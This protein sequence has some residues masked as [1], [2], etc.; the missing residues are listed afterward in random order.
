MVEVSL[1]SERVFRVKD[2]ARSEGTLTLPEVL[3]RL[4]R[5][6]DLDFLHLRPHQRPAWHAF[7]VQLAWLALEEVAAPVTMPLEPSAWASHLRALTPGQPDDAPWCLLNSD[8]QRPAFMQP[9]CAADRVAEFDKSEHAV[10]DIDVLVT[11][12]H[13]DE[14]AAKVPLGS[15][16]ADALVYALVALQGWSSFMGAGNYNTMR[17]NGGFGSRPHFRLASRRGSGAEFARDFEALLSAEE[18]W[19]ARADVLGLGSTE[20]DEHR[21]LWLPP[22]DRG[23]LP[24]RSVH[25]LCLEVTRRVRLVRDAG[26]LVLRRASSDAMRVAAKE[27][28][29]VV[30]DPWTPVMI[31]KAPRALTAHRGTLGYRSLQALLF[32]RSRTELPLLAEP[33]DAERGAARSATLLAQILL[34]GD[35]RTDGVSRREVRLPPKVLL[36]DAQLGERLSRRARVFVERAGVASGKVLRAALIQFLDGSEEVAWKNNDFS[37]AAQPWVER[38]EQ[39]IDEAFFGALFASVEAAPDDDSAATVHWDRWLAREAQAQLAV[40]TES[41]PTRDGCRWFAKARAE[42]LMALSLHKHLGIGAR[43][44]RGDQEL[45]ADTTETLD[46]A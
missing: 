8:W 4:A 11:S 23:S 43:P 12:R 19:R 10:Q 21:L 39:A 32:D 42:R 34:S 6:D 27:A 2:E 20:A 30:G 31:D 17:M 26:R 7:L 44:R 1:L 46:D 3:A 5:Q 18:E 16:P 9:P 29:G 35:G 15:A 38:Y 24:L 45:D 13:H 33:S 28:A 37:K 41:L 22:W 14:K 40:A 36:R 25:P